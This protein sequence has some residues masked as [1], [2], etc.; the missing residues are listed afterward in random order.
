MN[1]L[2]CDWPG[3]DNPSCPFPRNGGSKG[4]GK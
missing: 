3:C 2:P 1:I 4:G